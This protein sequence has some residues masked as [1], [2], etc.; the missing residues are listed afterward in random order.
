MAEESWRSALCPKVVRAFCKEST[1]SDQQVEKW[2]RQNS[3]TKSTR[4]SAANCLNDS[5]EKRR[6]T[7]QR[8]LKQ[9]SGCDLPQQILPAQTLSIH[10]CDGKFRTFRRIPNVWHSEC[11]K[12]G[13]AVA[14]VGPHLL[15]SVL[16][17]RMTS[18]IRHAFFVRRSGSAR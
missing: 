14:G 17:W 6:K 2:Q 10:C 3:M 4:S 1:K 5:A 9:S 12:V 13:S 8:K 18:V 16:A 15:P 11:I 7:R